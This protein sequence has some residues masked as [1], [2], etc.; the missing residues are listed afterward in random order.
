MKI[1]LLV[2]GGACI[3]IIVFLA[4][5]IRR[6]ARRGYTESWIPGR[7]YVWLPNEVVYRSDDPTWFR[8]TLG[9]NILV[10]F[11][12]AALSVLLVLNALIVY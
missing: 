10:V 11:V 4:S 6:D 9:T 3:P 12:V 7:A 8:V 5:R 1:L 2:G